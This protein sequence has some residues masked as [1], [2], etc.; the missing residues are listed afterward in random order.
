MVPFTELQA[1]VFDCLVRTSAASLACVMV[2]GAKVEMILILINRDN[3]EH[4][5]HCI[6]SEL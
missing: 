2:F 1:K 5:I 6:S 3:E 4:E